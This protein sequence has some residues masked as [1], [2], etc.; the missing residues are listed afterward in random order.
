MIWL[1]PISDVIS[2]RFSPFL[3]LLLDMVLMLPLIRRAEGITALSL[4]FIEALPRRHAGAEESLRTK[5]RYSRLLGFSSIF[6]SEYETARQRA[7]RRLFDSISRI[8]PFMSLPRRAAMPW[9]L[10]ITSRHVIP[11]ADDFRLIT[12][13]R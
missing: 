5:E 1:T 13:L 12:I 10:R 7:A 3:S 9:P 11:L 8:T 2:G 6:M 4:Y